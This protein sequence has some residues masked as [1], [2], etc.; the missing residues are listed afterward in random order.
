M[1]Y[2]SPYYCT[3]D[4]QAFSKEDYKYIIKR[5]YNFLFKKYFHQN[6]AIYVSYIQYGCPDFNE[7]FH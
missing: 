6:K 2:D 1:V 3:R 7:F 4:F 5:L